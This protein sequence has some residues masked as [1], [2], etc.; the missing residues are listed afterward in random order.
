MNDIIEAALE[1]ISD[2][3]WGTTGNERSKLY[4]ALKAH[5]GVDLL[6]SKLDEIY[7]RKHAAEI[8]WYNIWQGFSLA[9]VMAMNYASYPGA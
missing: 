9:G 5:F 4:G 8:A 7:R 3:S 1:C 6:R 2:T